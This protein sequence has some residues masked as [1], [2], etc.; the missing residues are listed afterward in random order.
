MIKTIGYAA[1]SATTPLEPFHFELRE[2][3]EHDVLIEVLYCGV[4]HSDIH[5]AR[6]EWLETVYPIVPGH[7]IIGRVLQVGNQVK[8]FKVG[9]SAGVG[10]IVDSCGICKSCKEGLE[11]FCENGYTFTFNSIDKHTGKMTYGGYSKQMVVDEKFVLRIP[12]AFKN[13]LAAAAPLLCAGITTYSPLRHWKVSKD[14]K[15]V[16][17]GIGG[18]GHLAVKIA[19]AMRAQVVEYTTTPDKK[20]D[21]QRLGA[22]D[23]VLSTNP[24]EMKKY[25]N[26]FD[27]ILNTIPAPHDLNA[28]L[29]LLKR[30]GTMCLVGIP[31]QPHP[32]LRADMLITER[33][34]LVGSVIGGIQETQEM[35]DFC[36]KNNITADIEII[37]I[38]KINEAFE[39]VIK[40]DVRYRFV[41]D[42]KSLNN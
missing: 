19:H 23:A 4:C 14:Q 34:Q 12:D 26:S 27:F 37:P 30:D 35:L 24:E 5:F 18:L 31:S 40:K 38:E 15:V 29:Q 10:C 11:Q 33:R 8:K 3:G 32:Y 16:V 21:A 9:D 2:P 42:M 17:A 1:K 25:L 6:N 20:G 41:I 36:A 13:S 28:Y 39:R 22:Q 7:E